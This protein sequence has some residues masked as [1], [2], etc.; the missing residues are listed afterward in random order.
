MRHAKK[1]SILVLAAALLSGLLILPLYAQDD[2][3]ASLFGA[4][5]SSTKG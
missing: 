1:S 4:E 2:E 5:A 3:R